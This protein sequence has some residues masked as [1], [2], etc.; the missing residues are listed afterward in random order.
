MSCM[1]RSAANP[2]RPTPQSPAPAPSRGTAAEPAGNA[3][4]HTHRWAESVQ[5]HSM[6]R[7]DS[8]RGRTDRGWYEPSA[9]KVPPAEVRRAE[10]GR[11]QRD[12]GVRRQ[13]VASL[14]AGLDV[15]ARRNVHREHGR[16][17]GRQGGKDAVERCADATLRVELE[18][19]AEDR[20]HQHAVLA[21]L[22][23]RCKRD[24]G[25][26]RAAGKRWHS[27]RVEARS[28][29]GC[30][31]APAAPPGCRRAPPSSALDTPPG[32]HTRSGR[33][34]AQRPSRRRRCYRGRR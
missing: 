27:R 26:G 33:D 5:A 14:R 25:S 2:T 34:A 7:I 20:V 19:E 18:T 16:R 23:A 32:P 3:R 10:F 30:P 6:A 11:R 24:S 21:K 22:Q 29:Q 12:Q 31:A 15:P 8:A 28:A 13:C 9:Q 17:R 1:R 4:L